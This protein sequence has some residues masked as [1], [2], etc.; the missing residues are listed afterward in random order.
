MVWDNAMGW[1]WN[2][3]S[4]QCP[5]PV[6]AAVH[7]A[8]IGGGGQ[9]VG[10]GGGVLGLGGGWGATMGPSH[11]AMGSSLQVSTSCVPVTS[12]TAARTRGSR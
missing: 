9:D 11:G 4:L 6:I 3:C 10:G 12:A 2:L 5:K 8:C 7:G 1:E